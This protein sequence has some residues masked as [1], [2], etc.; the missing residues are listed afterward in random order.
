MS[1]KGCSRRTNK[2]KCIPKKKQKISDSFPLDEDCA[3]SAHD[4]LSLEDVKLWSVSSLKAFLAMRNK[5]I[6]GDHSTLSARAYI[7]WEDGAPVDA[8]AEHKL[9]C[10]L[11]DYKDK[12]RLDNG[13][14]LPDPFSLLDG[15]RGEEA[16]SEWPC[17]TITDISYYLRDLT[18]GELYHQLMN[19]YKLGKAFRYFK[20]RH[21]KDVHI[22]DISENFP[23]CLL[24]VRVSPTMRTT[25]P[26]YQVWAAVEKDSKSVPGGRIHSAYCTCPVG[27][28]G[29]CNHVAGLLFR[30]ESAVRA[31]MATKSSTSRLCQ[32]NI[33]SAKNSKHHTIRL[34]DF[35]FRKDHYFSQDFGD[36]HQMSAKQ[37][38]SVFSPLSKEQETY[39]ADSGKVLSNLADIFRD[40][41]PDSCFVQLMDMKKMPEP[42]Q[43]V[44]PPSLILLAQ[45]MASHGSSEVQFRHQLLA[46]SRLTETGLQTIEK[47]TREQASSSVWKEHR[48]GRITASN[49]K[50]AYTR[51]STLLEK[52]SENASSIISCIEGTEESSFLS[53]AAKHGISMEPHAKKVYVRL[54]QQRHKKFTGTECGLMIHPCHQYLAATPDLVSH[55]KCHGYGVVEIK[56]P[57]VCI[58]KV[59]SS[60]NYGH[61]SEYGKLKQNS[62]HMFQV[63]GQMACSGYG[64]ADYFVYTTHGHHLERIRFNKNMWEE[65]V[66][67]FQYLWFSYVIPHFMKKNKF[68]FRPVTADHSYAAKEESCCR[69]LTLPSNAGQSGCKSIL[70]KP[71][72]P[73]AYLCGRCGQDCPESPSTFNENSIQ[74]VKCKV[75]L[76][77][78]CAELTPKTVPHKKEDWMCPVCVI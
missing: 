20:S 5:A 63:Q 40:E 36:D 62:F 32:W 30:I 38:G 31:G 26:D 16:M 50:R 69:P 18:T 11:S 47:L 66:K 52:P 23:V 48:C 4:K 19:E 71:V 7:A 37:L 15:W 10:N 74:C 60:D 67:K 25:M 42:P 44:C 41:V 43:P 27:L 21:V 61:L 1:V 58:D 9:R 72:Y 78:Q 17:L 53:F 59:P 6:D 76:H 39:A 2:G 77:F 24:S 12:L 14:T 13:L 22:H 55:C 75:W 8:S 64:H 35:K 73:I 34:R 49:M 57:L 45:Q 70:T 33:P 65:M 54:M 56:C 68:A 3:L 28:H 51:A 46:A 29:T